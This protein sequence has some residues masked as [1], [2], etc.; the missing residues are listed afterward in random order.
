MLFSDNFAT[1]DPAWRNGSGYLH[2]ENNKFIQKPPV[3]IQ[4]NNLYA[5][6]LFDDMDA[7]VDIKMSQVGDANWYAGLSFWAEDIDNCYFAGICP[8]NGNVAVVRAMKGRDIFPIPWHHDDAVKTGAEAVNTV[9][10]VTKGGAI[11]VFVN[12]KQ[13]AA[14]NGQPPAGGG[15]IG[16]VGCSGKELYVWEF[17]NLIVKKPAAETAAAVEPKRVESPK[18]AGSGKS[19]DEKDVIYHDDFSK[20]NPGWTNE[21]GYLARGG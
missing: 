18:A 3:E 4:A 19:S 1:L 12:G 2:A 5:G 21:A 11:T 13:V 17:S 7:S 15:M 20:L 6:S 16:V 14:F 10:V 9:R 8:K